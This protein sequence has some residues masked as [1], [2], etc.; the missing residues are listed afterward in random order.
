MNLIIP[1]H[2]EFLV[3]V[4][5]IRKLAIVDVQHNNTVVGWVAAKPFDLRRQNVL[6]IF[7]MMRE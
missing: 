3:H 5:K 1:Y 7:P 4:A 2:T 6:D